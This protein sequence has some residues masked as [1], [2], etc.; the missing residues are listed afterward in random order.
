MDLDTRQ[1]LDTVNRR[2]YASAAQEFSNTRSHPWPGWERLLP[3][4]AAR[5][6]PLAVL[7][8]GCGNGRFATFLA[9]RLHGRIDYLGI[10]SSEA[11]LVH[12]REQNAA[13]P[14]ARFACVDALCGALESEA[15][16][17]PFDL[18]VL[19]GLLHHVPGF[20]TRRALLTRLVGG[21]APGGLL[22]VAAWQFAA[23]E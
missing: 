7:D 23:F 9:E 19:F 18:V 16:T 8:V 15:L 17:R 6:E 13:L 2:F 11:L 14:E 3:H 10:D 5:S 21:L 4:L 20:E 22:A 1:A 12:A